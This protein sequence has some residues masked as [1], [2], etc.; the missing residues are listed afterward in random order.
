MESNN[1]LTSIS[2][3]DWLDL[4]FK[5]FVQHA[6][7][8]VQHFNYFIV[9]SSLISTATITTLTSSNKVYLIALVLGSIQILISF[10]F[11]KIDDRNRFLI[12]HSEEIIKQIEISSCTPFALFSTEEN[13]TKMEMANDKSFFKRS[14][15]HRKSYNIVYGVFGFI[16]IFVIIYSTFCLFDSHSSNKQNF[17]KDGKSKD[18]LN[19][20]IIESTSIDN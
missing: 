1:K 10:I 4:A 15:S 17:I 8:R 9:F 7:Q 20:K 13:V 14:Y 5:H 3:R 12:K 18:T 6:Q 16:G 19:I 11:I 2:D